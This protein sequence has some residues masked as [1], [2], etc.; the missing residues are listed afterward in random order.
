MRFPK[1]CYVRRVKLR[2]ACGYAQSDQSLCKSLEY[3]MNVK[4]F[5]V[6]NLKRM[7]H[8]YESHLLKCHI[9]GG[10]IIIYP[11]VVSFPSFIH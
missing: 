6:S 3:Y 9:V 5:G 1:M 10:S 7:I 4:L 11:K 8:S 2:S